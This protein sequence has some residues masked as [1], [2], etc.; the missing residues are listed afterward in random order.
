[1]FLDVRRHLRQPN[2]CTYVIIKIHYWTCEP[3]DVDPG[4]AIVAKMRALPSRNL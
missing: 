3:L 4:I 1:M 2:D